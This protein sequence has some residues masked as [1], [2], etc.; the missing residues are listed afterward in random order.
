MNI[1]KANSASAPQGMTADF[2]TQRQNARKAIKDE[3]AL[4]NS[5]N[6]PNNISNQLAKSQQ[7]TNDYKLELGSSQNAPT[8]AYKRDAAQNQSAI[9]NS[10]AK[11][12]EQKAQEVALKNSMKTTNPARAAYEQTMENSPNRD[13]L[14]ALAQKSDAI[15]QKA[16]KSQADAVNPQ[17]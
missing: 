9:V 15:I 7:K 12:G 3:Q 16:A 17:T 13:E 2:I 10:A 14:K 1:S 6:N 11:E 4:A 8:Q 5:L